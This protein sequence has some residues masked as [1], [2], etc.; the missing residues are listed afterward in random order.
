MALILPSA[1]KNFYEPSLVDF[2]AVLEAVNGNSAGQ[3]SLITTLPAD[4]ETAWAT[5]GA[6]NHTID[7]PTNF[8]T[9]VVGS[10]PM[11]TISDVIVGTAE[12]PEEVGY[13]LQIG[14]IPEIQVYIDGTGLTQAT[15]IGLCLLVGRDNFS[16]GSDADL[17]Y[18]LP[19]DNLVVT[20]GQLLSTGGFEIG[21]SYSEILSVVVMGGTAVP[22][23]FATP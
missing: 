23:A 2:K 8:G 20:D 13:K 18:M 11:G 14:A 1:T 7:S 3:V 16:Q 12:S 4:I 19:V 9:D 22:T 21:I 10:G 5:V 15:V 17:R 6:G